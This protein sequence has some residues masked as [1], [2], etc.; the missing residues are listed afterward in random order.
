MFLSLFFASVFKAYI[1]KMKNI[2]LSVTKTISPSIASV[3]YARIETH[4]QPSQTN[5]WSF[6]H[7]LLI[8][9]MNLKFG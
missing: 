5:A 3:I 6:Q 8:N 9:I 1:I 2:C 7:F 4:K